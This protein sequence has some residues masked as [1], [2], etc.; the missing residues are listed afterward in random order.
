MIQTIQSAA[1]GN[2]I[3]LG[4]LGCGAITAGNHLPSAVAH[5]H[6]RIAALV[7]CDLGRAQLLRRRFHLECE[8]AD[9]YETVLGKLDAVII[10][11]PNYLHV[12]AI[13]AAVKAGVHVL[14]EKPLA[15]TVAD[16]RACWEA[17]Q[18]QNVLLAV[19]MQWRFRDS[20]ALLPLVLHEGLLGSL[21]D[22]D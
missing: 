16:S 1:F 21:L 13:L 12:P 11:L 17:A 18:Q 7:D 5:P 20:S 14:C 22:Y 3:R 10:A 15:L 9:D 6:V 19:G 8:I 2:P 4:I